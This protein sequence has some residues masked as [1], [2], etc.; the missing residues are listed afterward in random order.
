[1]RVSEESFDCLMSCY[2]RKQGY[3][4]MMDNQ[5]ASIVHRTM[6]LQYVSRGG[7]HNLILQLKS[8]FSSRC[9]SVNFNEQL[10]SPKEMEVLNEFFVS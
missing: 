8:Q 5:F 1:M 3:L 4:Y 7:V 10:L 6:P 9:Y 2:L